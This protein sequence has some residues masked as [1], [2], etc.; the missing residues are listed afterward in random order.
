GDI[1][2]FLNTKVAIFSQTP[3]DARKDCARISIFKHSRAGLMPDR[4]LKFA[5]DSFNNLKIRPP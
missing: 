4:G 3:P 2:R 1:A 5:A